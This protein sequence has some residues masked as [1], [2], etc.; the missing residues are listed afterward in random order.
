MANTP[1]SATA[2]TQPQGEMKFVSGFATGSRTVKRRAS[3]AC[4]CCRSRKVRCDLTASGIP[5]TNCRLDRVECIGTE[6]K[7]RRGCFNEDEL[8][9]LPYNSIEEKLSQSLTL[10]NTDGLNESPPTT[11][12]L[13]T[14][15]NDMPGLGGG[16]NNNQLHMLCNA[17]HTTGSVKNDQTHGNRLSF[18]TSTNPLPSPETISRR[19][20]YYHQLSGH[21]KIVLPNYIQPITQRIMTEDL[22]YLESKGAFIIPDIGLRNE[23]LRCY[24]QFVHPF[25]PVLDLDDFLSAIEKNEPRDAV[26]LLL[27]Q[28]AMFASTAFV[29]MSY[30]IAQGYTTRKATRRLFFG[31]VKLLYDFDI[32]VDRIPLIQSLLLMTYWCDDL[33]EY[34]DIGHWLGIAVSLAQSIGLNRDTS[35]ENSMSQKQKCLWKRIWWSCFMRDRLIAV[36]TRRP[37]RI[38]EADFDVLPLE[39]A[40]FE[41]RALSSNLIK[42]LGSCPAVEDSSKRVAL[43]KMCIR[44]SNLCSYITS[45]LAVQYSTLGRKIGVTTET[46]MRLIPKESA[47]DPYAITRC[48]RELEQWRKA[49]PRYIYYSTSR[50]HERSTTNRDKVI[51]LHR[52]LL[53][54]IYLTTLCALHW[55]QI[56]TASPSI[57]IASNLRNLSKHRVWE[58]AHDFTKI[59]KDL[60][61]HDL[62]K[63]LPTTG[64]TCLLT[65]S[66]IYLLDIKSADA[67]NH[68][69]S[70][71]E[72]QFCLQALQRLR[73]IYASA[74]YVFSVLEAAARQTNAQVVAA[75]AISPEFLTVPQPAQQSKQQHRPLL[76]PS[77]E[78]MQTASLL[79][80]TCTMTQ[81]ERQ[82]VGEYTANG[83]NVGRN[84]YHSTGGPLVPFKDLGGP[85]SQKAIE[86]QEKEQTHQ[87]PDTLSN[88]EGTNDLFT[89]DHED[90]GFYMNMQWLEGYDVDAT[91]RGFSDS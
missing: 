58:A 15:N 52:A 48:D 19:L 1:T 30:L 32:E 9:Q 6:T 28:A 85:E 51:N 88:L 26:S 79:T 87:D 68:Q 16:L 40:D 53:T 77:P 59:Y 21:L 74:D 36:G 80:F 39:L 12:P 70:I 91:T 55:P 49:L 38:N 72:L 63:Y 41:T 13:E 61:A 29:D 78:A 73:E 66:S 86:K 5:C 8:L 25:L 56:Q 65:A 37:T 54:G 57:V 24:V 75:S 62:I 31:R 14:A 67:N 76:T 60:Y 10:D 46:T 34:K 82:F 23:L 89:S 71:D 81:D 11:D 43:A 83:F 69:T 47:T 33:D 18:A 4:H 3:K 50:P 35:K 22:K 27:F 20:P 17:L 64:V 42:M 44:L 45:I 84:S 90:D 2:S 7:R